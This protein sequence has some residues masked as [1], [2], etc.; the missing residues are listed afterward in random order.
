MKARIILD[1]G[2]LCLLAVGRASPEYIR[3]NRNLRNRSEEHYDVLRE[4]VAGAE[5]VLATPHTLTEASN[6]VR[7]LKD[8]ARMEA[9]EALRVLAATMVEKWIASRSGFERNEYLW[10]GLTDSVLLALDDEEPSA[11]E[12]VL[13]TEDTKLFSA[14]V[15]AGKTAL[16]FDNVFA[17]RILT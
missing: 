14:A 10:L 12:M 5:E 2:M 3:A 1:S 15:S 11:A 6:L 7:Q 13:L 17:R 8:P 4:I 16:L 9:T